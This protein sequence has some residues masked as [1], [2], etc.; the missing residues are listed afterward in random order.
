MPRMIFLIVAGLLSASVSWSE[1]DPAI[2]REVEA[3]GKMLTRK[4]ALY[5]E[6]QVT[7]NHQNQGGNAQQ[8]SFITWFFKAGKRYKTYYEDP[9]G[10]L[11][12]VWDGDQCYTW[13][14]SPGAKPVG[15][16]S[17]KPNWPIGPDHLLSPS[18]YIIDGLYGYKGLLKHFDFNERQ[19]QDNLRIFE[20]TPTD[21]HPLKANMPDDA[22]IR[23]IF[24][25]ETGLIH[26]VYNEIPGKIRASFKVNKHGFKGT[27]AII[28][29]KPGKIAFNE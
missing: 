1:T 9:N 3:L 5:F 16:S 19:E 26:A 29:R 28:L 13:T 23:L 21:N 7:I 18:D 6:G 27:P 17:D 14:E 4:K 25:A 12:A 20:L 22:V 2:T 8:H 11:N 10:R 24:D 15:E